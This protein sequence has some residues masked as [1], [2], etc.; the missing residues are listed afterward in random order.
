L[1][2]HEQSLRCLAVRVV[3]DAGEI[4]GIELETFLNEV[5]IS[6]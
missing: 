2:P 4:D 6:G 3:L 1:S 5:H